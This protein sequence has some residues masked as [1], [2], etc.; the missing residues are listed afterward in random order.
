MQ[1]NSNRKI[2][3]SMSTAAVK[4]FIAADEVVDVWFC[5][6][7]ELPPDLV[8]YLCILLSA[9]EQA[10]NKRFLVAGPRRL[11]AAAY[12]LSRLAV[13]A[14]L[15]VPP[16]TVEFTQAPSGKPFLREPSAALHFNLA[17]SGSLA[18]CAVSSCHAVGIDVEPLDRRELSAELLHD[19]LAPVERERIAGLAGSPLQEA[20]VGL[21]TGKEAVAK[22]HGGGLSLPLERLIVPEGDG[23][24]DMSPLLPNAIW[25]LHRLRPVP[26]SRVALA[27]A[28]PPDTPLEIRCRNGLS[29]ITDHLAGR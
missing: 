14:H 24:V 8:Q 7:D 25:R 26:G 3:S 22:A 27:I 23:A 12:A 13:A 28:T 20:L 18:V 11:H 5:N 17:H 1:D 10:R 15:K 9:G 29:M 4:Q 6:A 16:P 19:L 21:W 2:R